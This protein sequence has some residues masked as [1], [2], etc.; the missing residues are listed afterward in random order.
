MNPPQWTKE[1]FTQVFQN[2]LTTSK[3]ISSAAHKQMYTLEHSEHFHFELFLQIIQDDHIDLAIRLAASKMVF[4]KLQRRIN[5]SIKEVF[6]K[7][8]E[9][10]VLQQLE[11]HMSRLFNAFSSQAHARILRDSIC[12]VLCLLEIVKIKNREQCFLDKTD[13]N[14]GALPSDFFD[15]FFEF[16]SLFE[17]NYFDRKIK[18]AVNSKMREKKDL[19]LLLFQQASELFLKTPSESLLMNILNFLESLSSLKTDLLGNHQLVLFLFSLCFISA[20][21]NRQD[22]LEYF[23]VDIVPDLG[24]LSA[25][26]RE[27]CAKMSTLLKGLPL[28]ED[29]L[30]S[31]LSHLEK[32]FTYSLYSNEMIST[33]AHSFVS[34]LVPALQQISTTSPV[35]VSM[36]SLH[37][38]LSL[39]HGLTLLDR[40][41][42]P[43]CMLNVLCQSF[44]FLLYFR[45]RISQTFFTNLDFL[46][47]SL[48]KDDFS[49]FTNLFESLK[50]SI[51]ENKES[52]EVIGSMQVDMRHIRNRDREIPSNDPS[53][54]KTSELFLFFDMSC[55]GNFNPILPPP[56][57]NSFDLRTT[58]LHLTK[59][60]QLKLINKSRVTVP[61]H[62]Q[63]LLTQLKQDKE[64]ISTG[65]ELEDTI[66]I[67]PKQ[68]QKNINERLIQYTQ[69]RS[70]I[71]SKQTGAIQF[72]NSLFQIDNIADFR[73]QLSET[74]SYLCGIIEEL[75]GS[76]V[77]FIEQ[78]FRCALDLNLELVKT[79]ALTQDAFITIFEACV[80]FL[81]DILFRFEDDQ[82][83]A[84]L[85]PFMNRV[86]DTQLGLLSNP[87]ISKSAIDFLIV[88]FSEICHLS[89]ASV[90]VKVLQILFHCFDSDDLVIRSIRAFNI[91]VDVLVGRMMQANTKACAEFSLALFSVLE[92]RFNI[93]MDDT[94][95]YSLVPHHLLISFF[96]NALK[97]NLHLHTILKSD[98]IFTQIF[99]FCKN[100]LSHSSSNKSIQNIQVLFFIKLVSF[101]SKLESWAPSILPHL[102]QLINTFSARF[103]DCLLFLL[104]QDQYR[105]QALNSLQEFV[106]MTD[107]KEQH[108]VNSLLLFYRKALDRNVSQSS[109]LFDSFAD[110]LISQKHNGIIAEWLSSSFESFCTSMLLG[111]SQG[112]LHPPLKFLLNLFLNSS[113]GASLLR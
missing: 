46:I 71:F 6:P 70:P 13:G 44:P 105:N 84:L 97:Y 55:L 92:K 98:D 2:T 49:E 79:G 9:K 7:K 50:T 25:N 90:S 21:D 43:V 39:Q 108:Q 78:V 69:Q 27:I 10:P 12:R 54:D 37:L 65:D 20:T 64:S 88:F 53:I 41:F 83:Q 86:F 113:S 15:F 11:I 96:E 77:P 38:Y 22:L 110:F 102:C 94:K 80:L 5:N 99:I 23:L 58:I 91:G 73:K 16:S 60:Y 59:H 61:K 106:S 56:V 104:E 100:L 35:S 45:N 76:L 42:D 14:I 30:P 48:E 87:L 47:E 74:S 109:D 52:F 89:E 31:L 93:E 66:D 75:E 33:N 40:R 36:F 67:D 57:S 24:F 72:R 81:K 17:S 103:L 62:L 34:S 3:E 29:L 19:L 32:I 68:G 4:S 95:T 1:T 18:F 28:P 111:V 82:L 26:F 107:F 101:K 112:C 85:D 63:A 8:H 51:S